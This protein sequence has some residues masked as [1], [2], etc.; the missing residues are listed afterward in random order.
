MSGGLSQDTNVGEQLAVVSSVVPQA[1]G[2][3][4]AAGAAVDRYAH[5]GAQSCVLHLATGATTGT[6]TSF[7]SQATLQHSNDSGVSDPWTN[8]QVSLQGLAAATQQTGSVTTTNTD[9]SA[10]IP[11]TGAKRYIRASVA[12]TFSGGSSPTLQV[13]ADIILGGE[14]ELSAV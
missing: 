5:G 9:A 8:Y 14:Q 11:L 4:A 7:T 1:L 12:N 6:P 10:N 2:T 13:A 3:A